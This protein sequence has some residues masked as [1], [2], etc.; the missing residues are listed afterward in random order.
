MKNIIIGMSAIALV[1]T[2]IFFISCDKKQFVNNES[3]TPEISLLN[4]SNPN[5]PYDYIGEIHNKGLRIL[6]DEFPI[7]NDMS[8][9]ECAKMCIPFA[10][11]TFDRILTE[12]NIIVSKS[13]VNLEDDEEFL[14]EL[15]FLFD[16]IENNFVNFVNSLDLDSYTREQV[17]TLFSD[18]F[19]MSRKEEVTFSD[20]FDKIVEFETK[21]LDNTIS[22]LSNERES[23]LGGTSTLRHSLSFWLEE[24]DI[25]ELEI[26]EELNDLLVLYGKKWPLIVIG[27]VDALG[28]ILGG[29]FGGGIGAGAGGMC[30]SVAATV[31]LCIL[32]WSGIIDWY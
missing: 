14:S 21:V 24:L 7:S 30:A 25:N 18:I 6:L 22:I 4:P 27:G 23:V 20:I 5:N 12:S 2:V 28:A 26:N 9:K 31:V 8:I 15:E 17:Q 13:T 16:D 19:I 29:I 3:S 11:Q 10:S 1:F 32:N